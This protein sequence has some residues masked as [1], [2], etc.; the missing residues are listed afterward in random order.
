M[1]PAPAAVLAAVPTLMPALLPSPM[2]T[3]KPMLAASWT[4]PAA[5]A[6]V[7]RARRA[8]RGLLAEWGPPHQVGEVAELLVS[9]LVTNA[10]QHAHGPVVLSMWA[11]DG[12]LRCEVADADPRPPRPRQARE[13]DEGSRGLELV[14][15]LADTW[16]S[17]P[18]RRGKVVWFE[19]A[20]PGRA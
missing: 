16:G 10:V 5:A 18:T 20:A 8:A 14:Q 17:A 6:S 15:A 9:E 7:P 11:R 19:L 1:T 13:E 2:P 12:R 4:L 3:L